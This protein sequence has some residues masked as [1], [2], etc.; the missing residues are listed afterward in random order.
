MPQRLFGLL[1][2]ELKSH[3]N[4]LLIRP[5]DHM[6]LMDQR[7][8]ALIINRVRLFAALFAVLTPVWIVVDMVTLPVALAM[9]LTSLRLGATV[10]YCWLVFRAPRGG[11]MRQ[12]Y[13]SMA[14]L[15]AIPTEF[16]I[17]SHLILAKYQLEGIAAAI[18]TGYTFLPFVLLAGLAVFPLTLLESAL[19]T[20][21]LLIAD[22]I[23]WLLD[24]QGLDWPSFSGAFWLMALIAGVASLAS[25]SQL[26]FMIALV[27][28]AVRDPLTGCFSRR[29]AEEILSLQFAQS[30]RHGHPMTLAFIDLDRFK[31]INDQFGHEAGDSVLKNMTEATVN[32]LRR[33]DV[34][35]RW[36]GEEFLLMMPMTNTEQALLAL[37]RLRQ[38]GLGLRPDG[39]PLTA[40]IG[41]AECQEDGA[42]S[43]Q[44]LV[45]M[46]D[47]RM[48]RAKQGGRDRIVHTD[49]EQDPRIDVADPAPQELASC[50]TESPVA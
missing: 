48:Y 8:S 38:H 35:M 16:F 31:S 1:P 44:Q 10:A 4:G 24:W 50:N 13:I 42:E 49:H 33:D 28:Q 25:M 39:T 46:A 36:G 3:E 2:D 32:T 40:S 14:T 27:N 17:A 41:L 21:P 26:A 9:H 45:E 23:A 11:G 37:N 34:L 29:S 20:G 5:R 12:A 7:R 47:A 43:W 6:P 30:R 19:F 18:G 15:F 22:V